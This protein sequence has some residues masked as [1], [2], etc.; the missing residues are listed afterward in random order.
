MEGICE[1]MMKISGMPGLD[2]KLSKVADEVIEAMMVNP[3]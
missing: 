1:E 2:P 3:G